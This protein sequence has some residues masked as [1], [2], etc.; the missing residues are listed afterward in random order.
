MSLV[1]ISFKIFFL[2]FRCSVSLTLTDQRKTAKWAIRF[3]ATVAVL[4][5]A[6]PVHISYSANTSTLGELV[7]LLPRALLRSSRF[8]YTGNSCHRAAVHD[9]HLHKT[10]GFPPS[11]SSHFQPCVRS[12]HDYRTPSWYT[13][14]ALPPHLPSSLSVH[15]L[16]SA[17]LA[18]A[19]TCRLPF[20][21]SSI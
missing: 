5:N 3:F 21:L 17:R 1:V 11:P 18:Y 16:A 20:A 12:V 13:L 4:R 9:P 2:F 14:L 8:P 6:T 10:S 15:L 7:R 19:A